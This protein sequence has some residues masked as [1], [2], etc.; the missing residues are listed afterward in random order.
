MEN[1]AW[2]PTMGNFARRR[3][4]PLEIL[5]WRRGG[6]V[7]GARTK[8]RQAGRKCQPDPLRQELRHQ[9]VS[10]R[11]DWRCG[12]DPRRPEEMQRRK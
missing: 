5:A 4:G 3:G 6:R 2:R 8:Q 11:Q 10:R 12:Q 7:C 1:L 9:Q